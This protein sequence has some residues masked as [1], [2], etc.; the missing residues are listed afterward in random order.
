MFL[1]EIDSH[2]NG[3]QEVPSSAA[4]KLA[5]GGASG[6]APSKPKGWDPGSQWCESQPESEVPRTQGWHQS[7]EENV[8]VQVGSKP[9]LP[10]SFILSQA[11]AD[12]VR[13]LTW[14]R[15]HLLSPSTDLK[16][17]L[18]Q[19][20]LRDTPRSDALSEHPKAQK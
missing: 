15:M 19:K 7:Q 2:C 14:M 20:H 16:A 11:S 3:G 10:L 5:P 4:Y 8:P 17:S 6:V 13:P 1:K 9:A 18:F 12:W